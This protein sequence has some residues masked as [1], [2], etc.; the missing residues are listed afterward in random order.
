MITGSFFH[1][2]RFRI[3]AHRGNSIHH[4]HHDIHQYE[5]DSL[6]WISQDCSSTSI[7]S[8]PL[9]AIC[10]TAA[11]AALNACDGKN[12][13]HIIFHDENAAL[14][15]LNLGFLLARACV[16]VRLIARKQPDAEN[17]VTSSNSRSGDF[18]PLI[19]IDLE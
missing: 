6:A 14:Q 3:F 5:I 7:A 2:E 10:R 9:R 1:S 16:A 8:T 17:K 11:R 15:W 4:G 19:M 12:I 18:A 13:S